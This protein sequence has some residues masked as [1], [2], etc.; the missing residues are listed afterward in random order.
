MATNIALG[1]TFRTK[2]LLYV[3]DMK[4]LIKTSSTPR[5]FPNTARDCTYPLYQ[6][7]YRHP[8]NFYPNDTAQIVGKNT[9]SKSLC[10]QSDAKVDRFPST[11]RFLLLF[12]G[13]R[14]I[15]ASAI[16]REFVSVLSSADAQLTDAK[17]KVDPTEAP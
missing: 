3:G 10:V 17:A 13:P 15:P 16:P 5:L 14:L 7:L 1:E 6:P 11:D 9:S 12:P 2:S 4:S 8:R